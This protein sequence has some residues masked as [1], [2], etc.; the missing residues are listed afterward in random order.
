MFAI[1]PKG[2]GKRVGMRRFR[3]NDPDF[4]LNSNTKEFLVDTWD[5]NHVLSEDG[6][7]L[8]FKT[9]IEERQKRIAELKI[10][11]K[12]KFFNY[13][14]SS[15]NIDGTTT[16]PQVDLDNYKNALVNEFNTTKTTIQAETDITKIQNYSVNWPEPA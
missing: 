6:I 14:E 1:T 12:S 5:Q 4:L 3:M 2:T 11:A 10:Q 16:I 8:R 9:L 13:R 15:T 7:S